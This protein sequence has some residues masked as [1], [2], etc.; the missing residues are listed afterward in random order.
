ML[1][2]RDI[3]AAEFKRVWKG[4][5][6]DEVDNFLSRVVSAYESI[7]QE[8]NRLREEIAEL[9]ER[10]QGASRS[11]GIIEE[12]LTVA[13]QAAEDAKEAAR[14][15]A[16]ATLHRARMEAEAL[17]AEARRGVTVEAQALQAARRHVELFRERL[18]R[19]T[20]DLFRVIEELDA[21]A[22]L[23]APTL[24]GS[25][26]SPDAPISADTPTLSDTLT[27]SGTRLSSDTRTSLGA[28]TPLHAAHQDEAAVALDERS[29]DDDETMGR[30]V[31]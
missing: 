21:V 29:E 16:E 27:S 3:H 20:D 8:N 9:K 19:A 30:T 31:S 26:I 24:P 22:A 4:Y 15:E 10:L 17:L 6:P 5:S 7:Y 25:A 13:K 2:P 12:T 23:D 28:S 11:E 18:K 14:K 1:T